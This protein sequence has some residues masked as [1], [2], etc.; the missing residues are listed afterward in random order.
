[1]RSVRNSDAAPRRRAPYGVA[2]ALGSAL[3]AAACNGDGNSDTAKSPTARD[4]A[5]TATPA[6]ASSTPPA[7]QASPPV[8]DAMAPPPS[9]ALATRLAADEQ[10]AIMRLPAGRGHD[11]LV[12]NCLTCHAPTMIEQQHKDTAAWNK[13]V[14]T[15][16]SWGAPLTKEQQ[17]VLVAYL[18]EHFSTRAPAALKPGP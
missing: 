18:A 12:A 16:V 13:T 3:L 5:V 14:T 4:T 15:M 9:A 17:P 8:A 1:M 10:A 6:M 11:L 7:P 2:I